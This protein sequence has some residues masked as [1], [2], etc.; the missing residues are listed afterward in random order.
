L[1]Q[2]VRPLTFDVLVS[3]E[4]ARL[5]SAHPSRCRRISRLSRRLFGVVIQDGDAT[6]GRL[7]GEVITGTGIAPVRELRCCGFTATAIVTR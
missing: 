3:M 7:R 5:Q 2:T 6:T 4:R 1:G